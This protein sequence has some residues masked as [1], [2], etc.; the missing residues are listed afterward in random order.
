MHYN[1]SVEDFMMR[2]LG[3]SIVMYNIETFLER[4]FPKAFNLTNTAKGLHWHF[5]KI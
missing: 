2:N 3:K 4:V 1:E 5:L